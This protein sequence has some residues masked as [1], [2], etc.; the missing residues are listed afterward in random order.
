MRG[1]RRA[2]ARE[3][4]PGAI[5]RP[6]T[7]DFPRTAER[8]HFDGRDRDRAR[9]GG[10]LRECAESSPR[11]DRKSDDSSRLTNA[12]RFAG[13]PRLIRL[14]SNKALPTLSNHIMKKFCLIPLLAVLVV[15]GSC[16]KQQTE[17]ERKA[18]V[19]RQV[20]D[21]LAAERADAEK[22]RLADERAA[23]DAREKA[24]AEREATTTTAAAD[25]PATLQETAPAEEMTETAEAATEERS[26]ESYGMFYEKLD[27]YGEWRETNDYGYVWQPRE[28]ET[29]RDWRPY[30]EGRWAYSD[31]GWTWIS[32]EPF[33]W[34]TYHYGRW[35][36]LRR[37]GWVWVPGRE[38]APAWVSWRT[39]KDYVGWA[40]LPPEARFDRRSGIH[41]WA[42]NYYDIGPDQYA[43][44][45]SNDFGAEHVRRSVVPAERNISIV[46]ETTNVTRIT[47][48]NTMIR[49]EGPSYDELRSR[50]PRQIDRYRLRR[51]RNT[52]AQARV[53]G[54]ELE[55]SV[56]VLSTVRNIFKPRR[57][58]ERV[59]DA[60]VENGWTTVTDR[61]ATERARTKIRAE[62]TPPP[63][64]PSK[65]FV[66]PVETT[67]ASATP[68][69]SAAPATSTTPPAPTASPAAATASPT[70]AAAS[71]SPS[72]PKT[73]P[74]PAGSA[75][76]ATKGASPTPPPTA[77]AAVTAAPAASATPRVRPS[78]SIRPRPSPTIAVSPA[79]SP[80]AA[81][82]PAAPAV[83]SPS[84]AATTAPANSVAPSTRVRPSPSI[85]PR[86][87]QTQPPIQRRTPPSLPSTTPV[88][89]ATPAIAPEMAITP[90]VKPTVT[91]PPVRRPSL[92]PRPVPTVTPADTSSD[93]ARPPVP[94]DAPR[95]TMPPRMTQPPATNPVITPAESTTPASS[96][97]PTTNE[98]PNNRRRPLPPVPGASPTASPSTAP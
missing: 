81:T 79:L 16:Q 43:F 94:R 86:P 98:R 33:G 55:V 83:A 53:R 64:A 70:P 61:S 47:F 50:G 63:N 6:A 27:S 19:E 14:G 31:A 97:P 37:I 82:T 96:A 78:A 23:L 48:S 18:E 20:Q 7:R 91:V 60:N 72:A 90:V 77:T 65:K 52:E 75:S 3:T 66:K 74:T 71:P 67:S 9:P 29:A 4:L 17:E 30:T 25:T 49:N 21:R 12:Y 10:P 22:K 28:A 44:V 89:T 59:V 36:R 24:I 38:W 1:L 46:I 62:A 2:H 69:I 85:P 56:P 76:P 41:N 8:P 15:F 57:V 34:A 73:S 84:V 11:Q 45:S 54:D 92:T 95:R 5:A 51:D 93:T 13:S 32:D 39:S 26:T 87:V 88:A 68:A 40:P 42:D 58:K 80:S 35:V